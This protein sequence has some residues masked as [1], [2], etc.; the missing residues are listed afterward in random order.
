MD[1]F[2]H[3]HWVTDAIAQAKAD[4]ID[5]RSDVAVCSRKSG[6]WTNCQFGQVSCLEPCVNVTQQ[7][8]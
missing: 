8:E 5:L 6:P 2:D 3:E 1:S 7:S 4:A